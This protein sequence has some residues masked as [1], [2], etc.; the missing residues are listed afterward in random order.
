M[1]EIKVVINDPKT[2]RSAQK[3]LDEAKSKAVYNLKIGDK[4]D[5]SKIDLQGYEFI[6]TGGSDKSGTPMRKDV[7]GKH[8]KKILIVKGIGHKKSRQGV[9][10]RKTVAGNTISDNITQINAKITK[11][12][13]D[14]IEGLEEKKPEQKQ[15]EE[16]PKE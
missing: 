3:V 16:K 4:L 9:R 5:G 8:K 14:K 12:G 6:I 11:Y 2:K 1:P 13:K 15:Q 10:K 7:E